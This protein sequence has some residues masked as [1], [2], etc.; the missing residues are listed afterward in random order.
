MDVVSQ[1]QHTPFKSRSEYGTKERDLG[2]GTYGTVA[3][4]KKDDTESYAIKNIKNDD[5]K[6]SVQTLR[7]IAILVRLNHPNIVKIQ[8]VLIDKEGLGIVLEAAQMDLS[9]YIKTAT[10]NINHKD[11]S[12]QLARGLE[13][14]HSKGVWHRDIKPQ[15]IL[16]FPG[17]GG[18]T[19]IK[20]TDFGLARFGAI[21]N[22]LYSWP[23]VTLWWR[24]PEL[25]LGAKK[26]GPEIDVWSLGLI[27][28]HLVTRRTPIHAKDEAETLRAIVTRIGGMTEAQWPGISGMKNFP[29]IEKYNEAYPQGSLFQSLVLES[30][31]GSDGMDLLRKMLTSN[32]TN[33]ISSR[34]VINHP[35]FNQPAVPEMI[36]GDMR[37]MDDSPPTSA[38]YTR[39]LTNGMAQILFQW[40]NEVVSEY[41]L[42]VETYTY[43]RYLIDRYIKVTNSR[44]LRQRFQ[45]LGTAC[46]SIAAKIFEVFPPG[47]ED[48]IYITDNTFNLF[49]LQ[50]MTEDILKQLRFQIMFPTIQEYI[51]Y[52][53]NNH[54]QSIIKDSNLVARAAV[55]SPV[56]FSNTTTH[57]LAASI[58]YLVT[59]PNIP[60]CIFNQAEKHKKL[61]D[62]IIEEIRRLQKV[63]STGQGL[64][65]S[66]SLNT[67]LEVI[68]VR[69]ENS[70]LIPKKETETLELPKTPVQSVLLPRLPLS[71]PV[72]VPSGV[73]KSRTLSV[74]KSG[75]NVSKTNVSRIN[76]SE[77]S[78]G[79]LP[80]G[81]RLSQ[82]LT[83][84][85]ENA[86]DDDI[87]RTDVAKFI[88]DFVMNLALHFANLK[89]IIHGPVY[90]SSFAE[91]FSFAISADRTQYQMTKDRLDRISYSFGKLTVEMDVTIHLNFV[92]RSLVPR[93]IEF[94][95]SLKNKEYS[96]TLLSAKTK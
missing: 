61:A 96:N 39:D 51:Y 71:I 85:F 74:P 46:L 56:L 52:Y 80:E 2:E 50:E 45:L 60:Q 57:D 3:L 64:F 53:N 30:E 40:L 59:Y 43:A 38:A 70:E 91:Y 84:T 79:Q 89:L 16:V 90:A 24:S 82:K 76:V 13:Y 15:N 75:N 11:I 95:E 54:T 32:P 62:L 20:Y 77:A 72:H 12:L 47:E 66:V 48:F 81:R 55:I 18:Q 41:H 94:L 14:M 26:Y 88:N 27:F 19:L 17:P 31:L 83:F 5:D 28:A 37:I 68:L 33:R 87:N 35:Y 8:D 23:V 9:K 49:E 21:P 25:L 78:E 36:C 93:M 6:F 34:Q 44:T 73:I 92:P 69:Y 86:T 63:F 10:T 22:S 29:T 65:G 67:S 58:V 7:E 1:Y 4:Y 42:S